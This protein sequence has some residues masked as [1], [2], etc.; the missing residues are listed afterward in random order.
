[1]CKNVQNPQFEGPQGCP[2]GPYGQS[3]SPKTLNLGQGIHSGGVPSHSSHHWS[4]NVQKCA[5]STISGP[6]GVPPGS[7]WSILESYDSHF[8]SRNPF[9][10][11]PMVSVVAMAEVSNLSSQNQSKNTLHFFFDFD[12]RYL[13]FQIRARNFFSW[14]WKIHS[15]TVDFRSKFKNL[16]WANATA[17][18]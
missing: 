5:K 16:E 8:R 11:F 12:T 15:R 18:P 2:R 6:P 7:I 14:L 3:W 13:D 17:G 10:W 9:R 1:M 4:V